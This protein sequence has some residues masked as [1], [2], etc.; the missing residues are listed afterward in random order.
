M[1]G[2]PQELVDRIDALN[3]E[4]DTNEIKIHAA[5]V[6]LQELAEEG[7]RMENS[8]APLQ[9]ELAAAQAELRVLNIANDA[10]L[11]KAQQQPVSRRA[12]NAE[13][14]LLFLKQEG[15]PLKSREIRKA[16]DINSG[17]IAHLKRDGKILH[18]EAA[19][20]YTLPG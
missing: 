7:Q 9:I 1:T 17:E 10:W 20:T 12:T 19:Q 4:I 18:D 15:R 16:L 11:A 13:R 3:R 6:R 14:V 5:R 8:I 2:I